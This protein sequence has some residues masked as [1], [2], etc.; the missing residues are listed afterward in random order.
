MNGLCQERKHPRKLSYKAVFPNMTA[1]TGFFCP[2]KKGMSRL[3][4]ILL[5]LLPGPS[6]SLV[7]LKVNVAIG[8]SKFPHAGGSGDVKW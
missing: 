7:A 2:T 6:I 8:I 1:I 5:P 4:Y 3:E